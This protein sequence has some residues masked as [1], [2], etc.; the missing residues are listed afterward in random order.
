MA[1]H[2]HPNS[3]MRTHTHTHQRVTW[4]PNVVV[5]P[6]YPNTYDVEADGSKL[7]VILGYIVSLRLAWPT[8][9]SDKQL[10]DTSYM[11][12]PHPSKQPHR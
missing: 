10:M 5:H 3:R 8:I 9:V 6:Y 12:H 4:M 2:P 1:W 7:K 11:V